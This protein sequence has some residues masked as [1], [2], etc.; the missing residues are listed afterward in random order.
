MTYMEDTMPKNDEKKTA[1]KNNRSA[2]LSGIAREDEDKRARDEAIDEEVDEMG[3][4]P[5]TEAEGGADPMAQLGA[6]LEM[7]SQ[8]IP[9]LPTEVGNVVAQHLQAIIDA[10]TRGMGGGRQPAPAGAAT[11]P[12]AAGTPTGETF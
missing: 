6:G 7:I 1:E 8:V 5:M 2:R 10:V 9:A 12:A 11:T 4:A 3:G